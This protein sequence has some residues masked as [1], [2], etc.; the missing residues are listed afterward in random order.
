MPLYP[1]YFFAALLGFAR[2]FPIN[3]NKASSSRVVGPLP[4]PP[5]LVAQ[6]V[7]IWHPSRYSIFV[8]PFN[9]DPS[10]SKDA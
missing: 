10:I 7:G 6:P 5:Y 1:P 3:E 2:T 8:T 4:C 9:D